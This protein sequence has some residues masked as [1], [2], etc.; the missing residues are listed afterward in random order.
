MLQIKCPE[1]NIADF[2]SSGEC[3]RLIVQGYML[4]IECPKIIVANYRYV[5]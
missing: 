4:H 1:V 3:Y 2:V 5:S